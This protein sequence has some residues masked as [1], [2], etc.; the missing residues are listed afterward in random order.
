M[1]S[2]YHLRAAIQHPIVLHCH[3]PRLVIHETSAPGHHSSLCSPAFPCNDGSQPLIRMTIHIRST[4]C[5]ATRHS[6][7]CLRHLTSIM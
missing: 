5:I 1:G 3:L 4:A 2:I 7:F 6:C